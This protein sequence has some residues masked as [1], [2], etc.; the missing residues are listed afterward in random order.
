MQYH[1]SSSVYSTSYVKT[2]VD[3]WKAAQ[4]SA[5]SE[6]RLIKYSEVK[7]LGYELDNVAANETYIPSESTPSW[8][9]NSNYYYFI[10]IS[11]KGDYG[12]SIKINCGL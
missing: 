1:S 7:E 5:A 3:A 4:A 10:N 8:V 9:Y 6:A 11:H 12:L 2:T